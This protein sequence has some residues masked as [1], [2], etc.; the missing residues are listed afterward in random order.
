MPFGG[1]NIEGVDTSELVE[2]LQQHFGM[3]KHQLP[4]KTVFMSEMDNARLS[5][6]FDK[7]WEIST[8]AR[9]VGLG[10]VEIAEINDKIESQ[11]RQSNGIYVFR[12]YLFYTVNVETGYKYSDTFQIFPVPPAQSVLPSL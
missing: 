9:H 11:L 5:I 6:I 4:R 1:L 10:D 3:A 2:L 8:I 7:K 12:D